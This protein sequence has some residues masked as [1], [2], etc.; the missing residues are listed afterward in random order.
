MGYRTVVVLSNDLSSE[1]A[2]DP[3]LGCKISVAAAA[4]STRTHFR[5]GQVIECVHADQQTLAVLHDYGG[6]GVAHSSWYQ[7]QTEEA[8]NLDLLK[9]MAEKMGYR[10]VRRSARAGR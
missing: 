5:Y 1:W 3:E 8:R 9:K 7:N 6:T 2:N 4:T 10:L